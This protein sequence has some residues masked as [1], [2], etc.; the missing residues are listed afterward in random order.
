M[1]PVNS[2]LPYTSVQCI[3]FS[4]SSAIFGLVTVTCI[5]NGRINVRDLIYGA[6]AGGIAGG[7]P[8]YFTSNI[9]YA[10][11]V[12]YLAGVFQAIF[13]SIVER[14]FLKTNQPI[15]TVS[16]PLFVFQGLFGSF[17]AAGWKHVI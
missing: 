17:F 4:I 13:Q 10:L 11:I 2:F 3:I 7:A 12:G 6:V 16:I 14:N 15:A 5:I 8:S 1:S 9:V